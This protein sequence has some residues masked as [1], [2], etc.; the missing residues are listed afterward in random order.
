M[1]VSINE[2][3]L[4]NAWKKRYSEQPEDIKNKLDELKQLNVK[5]Y[6]LR[7]IKRTKPILQDGD[8]FVLS[9]RENLF[10]YG[11]ILKAN[12][13][14][15]NN[16]IFI[17]GKNVAFIFK[18]RTDKPTIENYKPDYLEL[19]IGPFIVDISYWNKGLF[20][21]VGNVDIS[22]YEQ[23]LDYGFYSLGKMEY[24]KEDGTKL[25]KKPQILG[26]YGI[27]TISGVASQIER[28]LI[29][30]ETLLEI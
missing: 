9:P 26:T 8:V 1:K 5:E 17:Q 23:E 25:G 19:L 29:I 14:H 4:S 15:V 10:F 3:P 22:D 16:D 2:N 7:L 6:Q 27:I 24:L 30:D 12:I 28:E 18:S 13:M 20:Y 11:K 21:N